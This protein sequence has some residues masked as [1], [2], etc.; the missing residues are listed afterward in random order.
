M[1]RKTVVTGVPFNHILLLV[2]WAL[3]WPTQTIFFPFQLPQ[4]YRDPI[5]SRQSFYQSIT[6]SG[7]IYLCAFFK[8]E[9]YAVIKP[10]LQ[11]TFLCKKNSLLRKLSS[12]HWYFFKF[13]IIVPELQSTFCFTT[14]GQSL[15][16]C[17]LPNVTFTYNML[18]TFIK[19]K[20]ENLE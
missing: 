4:N 20:S 8:I 9:C 2:V 6:S 11:S 10:F 18:L 12:T 19:K 17:Q 3:L 1:N 13:E 16:L 7:G 15:P 5:E 14:N